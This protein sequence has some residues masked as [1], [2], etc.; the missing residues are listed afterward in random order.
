[1]SSVVIIMKSTY[2]TIHN[3]K[4]ETVKENKACRLKKILTKMKAIY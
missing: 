2:F 4:L 3:G 1:M